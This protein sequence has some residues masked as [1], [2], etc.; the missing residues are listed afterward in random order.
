MGSA[1]AHAGMH[2]WA[3]FLACLAGGLAATDAALQHNLRSLPAFT[4]RHGRA[5]PERG[6][7]GALFVRLDRRA[8]TGFFV[9]ALL[10][11]ALAT[12]AVAALFAAAAAAVTLAA[13]VKVWALDYTV[14]ATTNDPTVAGRLAAISRRRDVGELSN[15]DLAAAIR[16]HAVARNRTLLSRGADAVFRNTVASSDVLLGVSAAACAAAGLAAGAAALSF[17]LAP[18]ALARRRLLLR[19]GGGDGALYASRAAL[20]RASAA[21]TWL[22][23][24]LVLAA[25]AART[26]AASLALERLGVPWRHAPGGFLPP[27]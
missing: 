21:C 4:L 8:A 12:C 24:L 19:V 9:P 7:H 13:A 27:P 17:W 16:E 22:P 2:H 11:G 6:Q 1:G 26:R 25:A 10:Q 5:V 3:V 23:L 15:E 14:L 18:A 20:S